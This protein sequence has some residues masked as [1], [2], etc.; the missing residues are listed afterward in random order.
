MFFKDK[1]VLVTGAA[2][3]TG[4]NLIKR[5]L[6]EGA[7]VRGVLH[8]RAPQVDFDSNKISYI[9]G[10]LTRK[11]DCD[12][13]VETMDFVFMCAANTSGAAVIETN[14]L[15]HVT[16][17]VLMNTLM[18]DASYRANVKKFLFIS[19]NTVYPFSDLYLKE[20]DSTGELFDK[21]FCVGSMKR[22]TEILCEK[23]STQ[24]HQNLRINFQVL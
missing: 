18:L 6:E 23:F 2:G 10:D 17:N 7:N 4:T 12:K 3:F 9:Y 24:N 21:Y 22:F 11:Q 8:N 13:A 20:E 5:L 16:P 19:S 15:A 14:P 1:N